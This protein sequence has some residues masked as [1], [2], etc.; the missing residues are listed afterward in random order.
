MNLRRRSLLVTRTSVHWPP[1][2]Y[3]LK[4]LLHIYEITHTRG[5]KIVLRGR[6]IGHSPTLGWVPPMLEFFCSWRRRP[7]LWARESF[8][9]C[10]PHRARSASH[11]RRYFTSRLD[12]PQASSVA[13][14]LSE[15]WNFGQIECYIAK[16]SLKIYYLTFSFV[17]KNSTSRVG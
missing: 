13:R 15:F 8:S 7:S 5:L 17:Y 10:C 12:A 4:T 3:I 6:S 1:K 9:H 16:K 14:E 11:H 2:I